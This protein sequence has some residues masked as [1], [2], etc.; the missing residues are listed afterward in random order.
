MYLWREVA[1]L[2]CHGEDACTGSD[3]SRRIKCLDKLRATVHPHE[4]ALCIVL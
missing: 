3:D 1:L 2:G 4:K